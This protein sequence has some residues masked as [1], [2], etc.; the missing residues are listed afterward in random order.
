MRPTA[1]HI[2]ARLRPLALLMAAGLLG[3]GCSAASATPNATSAAVTSAPPAT[4]AAIP[5]AAPT[6]VPATSQITVAGDPAIAGTITD[7]S[8]Q[9]DVPTTTGS[10]IVLYHQVTAQGLAVRIVLSS[11]SITVRYASG[12]GKTYLE[13][14]FSG[15]GVTSFD[16]TTGA[17]FD[18]S[19][20]M[21]PSST[22]TGSLG[23]IDSIKGNVECGNQTA[24]TSSLTITG[25]TA[26]GQLTGLTLS[27]VRVE[28]DNSAAYGK[29]VQVDGLATVG[30]VAT[31]F[32]VD[33]TPTGFTVAQEPQTGSVAFYVNKTAGAA[34]LSDTGVQISGV[35][36]EELTTGSTAT[37]HTLTVAGSATCGS[38]VAS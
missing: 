24:G 19:L 9:C 37:P 21:V 38:F 1:H 15:T 5:T 18:T 7:A 26:M 33:G 36:T 16:A 4:P 8:V 32:I 28:C 25:A 31:I 20:G 27:P 23:A 3:A 6:K 10:T 13:R 14:D 17:Q 2:Q 35:A 12:A 11:D 34:T 30:S 22:A 29:S